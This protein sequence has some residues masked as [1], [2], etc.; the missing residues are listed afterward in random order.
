M[1]RAVVLRQDFDGPNLRRLAKPSKD[2]RQ[3]PRCLA[4]VAIYDGGERT[5]ANRVGELSLQVIRTVAFRP[6]HAGSCVSMP[7][8][9][10]GIHHRQSQ[11]VRCR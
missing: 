7:L 10:G 6:L 8:G 3:S 1:G 4:L 2:A 9:R 5:D 11:L